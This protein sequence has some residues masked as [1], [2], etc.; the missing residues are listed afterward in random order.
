MKFISF[1][2]KCEHRI[3]IL[4]DNHVIDLHKADPDIPCDMLECIKNYQSIIPS[5]QRVLER[6]NDGKLPL[7]TFFPLDGI[8]LTAPILNPPKIIAIARNY[9]EKLIEVGIEPPECPGILPKLPSSIIGHRESIEWDPEYAQEVDF[10]VELAVV[11]GQRARHV[12]T[13]YALDVI[14][15]FTICNDVTDRSLMNFDEPRLTRAKSLD[16]FCPIGP[17]II[18]KDELPDPHNLRISCRLNGKTFQDSNTKNLIFNIPTIIA[19]LTRAFTLMPGDLILTGTPAGMGG[20]H[21]PPVFLKTG[22]LLESEIE[23]V[24]VLINPCH[25]VAFPRFK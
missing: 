3:G 20:W 16:T 6:Y 14:F 19:Y 17:S 23:G 21:C 9:A 25:E 13:E 8:K 15:G 5:T 24:G 18:T 11:I 4:A 1:L 2:W 22:D 10:G 7:S 12:P